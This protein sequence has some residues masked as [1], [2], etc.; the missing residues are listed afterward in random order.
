ML[1]EPPIWVDGHPFAQAI[2]GY[3]PLH[4]SLR[5]MLDRNGFAAAVVTLGYAPIMRIPNLA[6][7]APVP[8][9]IRAGHAGL[10][11][12]LSLCVTHTRICGIGDWRWFSS[13]GGAD[14]L[15]DPLTRLAEP[16][17]VEGV[18]LAKGDFPTAQFGPVRRSEHR[19]LALWTRPPDAT[20]QIDRAWGPFGEDA[21]I[22]Y[23]QRDRAAHGTPRQRSDL[24]SGLYVT[25]TSR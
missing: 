15:L 19:K 2:D 3:F 9:N 7:E 6:P 10:I 17:F 24:D 16:A 5:H 22:R 14:D 11:G 12:Q 21:C 18:G 1:S 20:M 23:V 25:C 4:T 8:L 13:D